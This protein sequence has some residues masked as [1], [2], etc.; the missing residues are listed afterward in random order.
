MPSSEST[1]AADELRRLGQAVNARTSDVVE[2]MLLRTRD[3]DCQLEAAVE[4]RFARVGAVSTVAVA[5]WMSGEG[6]D[7]AREVGQEAWQIFGQLASQR[8]APLNEVTKRCLRWCDAAREIVIECAEELEIAPAVLAEGLAMLQRSLNVTLVRMCE[9]FEAARQS[10]DEELA[11]RQR[12]L[13]YLATHDELTGLPNR[14]LILDRVTQLL[15]RAR[16]EQTPIAALFIDLDNF[17]SI[18]DTLG[19]AA[20]DELL[21]AVASRLTAVVRESDAVGRLGGDEFVVIASDLTF[22]SG[23]E[24]IA[25]RLLEAL[26]QPFKLEG[27]GDATLKVT[28]SIGVAAGDR[29]CADELLRDADIAMYQAKWDGRHRYMLFE[30][31][32]QTAVQTR[33][34]LEMDLRVALERDEFF[35]VYQPTFNLRDMSPTGME[36]LL[37]WKNPK[38]GIVQPND[39]VPLLEETGLIVEIGRWVLREACLQGV[40]WRESGHPV[41]VAVNVS[42]R[43]LDSDEFVGEV[44]QI[45]GE[46]GLEADSLTIEITETALMRDITQTAERLATIKELGVRIAI[47]DFGTGY[48]SMAH[49]QRFSVD[50]LK[51]DRSFITQMTH[52][53]EGET[54]IRTLVQLGKALSIETLA[55]GIE[56]AHELSLLQGES[57]DSGQGFLFARPL[58]VAEAAAFLG[59]WADNKALATS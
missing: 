59:E 54:I 18:N 7:V 57:C 38:R 16:R 32:M 34:E 14:T 19:H 41:G 28:A 50:A 1:A 35:L 31:G 36:A 39:F 30:S 6:P 24:L 5:R 46:T 21:R 11:R 22:A 33:M 51:I 49:L 15:L 37:R 13:A 53:Q 47:D 10:A 58:E 40:R 20:G 3:S 42:A 25:E 55:E 56:Q 8:A 29:A 52:N 4:E 44:R 2:A 45:L 23:P 9:S 48:S 26:D 27:T 12:E 43:Q 17:K